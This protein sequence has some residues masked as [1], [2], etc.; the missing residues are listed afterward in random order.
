[1]IYIED[2]FLNEAEYKAVQYDIVSEEF[3]G[4]EVGDKVFHVHFSSDAVTQM[5][6]RAVSAREGSKV[7]NILSFYR[8]ATD[9]IDTD[10]R[11]HSD[12]KINGQQPLR[13]VVL[14]LSPSPEPHGLTGTAFW[15]HHKYGHKL[16]E[17]TPNEEFDRALLEDSNDISKWELSSVVGHVPNRL[18]SYPASYFHSKYPN[19]AWPDGRV[20]FVMFY[21]HE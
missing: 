6:E 21:S 1:M 13:A 8:V 14:Y 2:N 16:P 10:W 5:I 20:I 9:T 15:K 7:K 3:K 4:V 12:Q 11:I 19:E 17:N 18:V